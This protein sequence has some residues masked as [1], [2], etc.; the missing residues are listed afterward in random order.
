MPVQRGRRAAERG[1]AVQQVPI[2][3]WSASV[4]LGAAGTACCSE[5]LAIFLPAHAQSLACLL[6]VIFCAVLSRVLISCD[7]R[8]RFMKNPLGAPVP[9]DFRDA[10]YATGVESGG[11][12]VCCLCCV[13]RA[14]DCVPVRSSFLLPGVR[15]VCAQRLVGSLPPPGLLPSLLSWPRLLHADTHLVVA[16]QRSEA[17][18]NFLYARYKLTQV[19]AEATRCLV[20]MTRI[21]GLAPSLPSRS[22]PGCCCCCCCLVECA[23]AS[24]FVFWRALRALLVVVAL[25]RMAFVASGVHARN[26]SDSAPFRMFA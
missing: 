16:S 1:G 4:L 21:S 8:A 17:E 2:A 19:Q 22:L 11:C 20:S 5:L 9:P 7:L 23:S 24:L 14:L 3:F 13:G 15:C 25:R 12:V 10:V 18:F 6:V 26:Q